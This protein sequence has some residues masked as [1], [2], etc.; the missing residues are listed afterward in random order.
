NLTQLL[1]LNLLIVATTIAKR[2]NNFLSSNVLAKSSDT[3]PIILVPISIGKKLINGSLD[4]PISY[5]PTLVH[6]EIPR[7]LFILIQH[8]HKVKYLL[9]PL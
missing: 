4:L 7:R 6:F 9:A 2:T 8:L 5:T 3:L 1:T